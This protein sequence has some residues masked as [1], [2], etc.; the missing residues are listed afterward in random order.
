MREEFTNLDN[1]RPAVVIDKTVHKALRVRRIP[2]SATLAKTKM[3][4]V[5][6]TDYW[7]PDLQRVVSSG[8]RLLGRSAT[9][10]VFAT[11]QDI[12]LED[13][14]WS[15]HLRT[16]PSILASWFVAPFGCEGAIGIEVWRM[17]PEKDPIKAAMRIASAWH[18]LAGAGRL[19]V[20]FRESATPR[21]VFVDAKG[22]AQE[23]YPID[24]SYRWLSYL[25]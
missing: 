3:R 10:Q 20:I 23:I 4:L 2:D 8:V 19:V 15:V 9:Y 25:S 17:H 22:G 14:A 16:I 1:P 21:W 7:D 6:G 5:A 18:E 13:E 12:P 11:H 24:L